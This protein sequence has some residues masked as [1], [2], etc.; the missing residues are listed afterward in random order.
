MTAN[1]LRDPTGSDK[2]HVY[3]SI[4]E[5]ILSGEL[6]S[7]GWLREGDLASTLGVS[8]TP[9]R[10]AF[11]RLAA[12]GLVHHE[13]NRGVQVKSWSLDDLDEIFSLRTQLEPWGCG[14]A[15]TSGHVD[16]DELASLASAMDAAAAHR[17]PDIDRITE[18]NNRFHRTILEA[19]GNTRLAAILTSLVQVPLVWRT[20]SHY[21]AEVLH[22]SLAHHHEIVAAL[23]AQDPIWAE[24]VMRS[25]VRNAWISIR[26][27]QQTEAPK[28]K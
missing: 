4:R 12:E 10:E 13:R 19:A 17:R 15:A 9:V 8:R 11:R 2:D 16:L 3:R 24:A 22:R 27:P 28:A 6:P 25:H 21:S 14:L 20:F 26:E 7:G 1:A 23:A 5:Q 18:I